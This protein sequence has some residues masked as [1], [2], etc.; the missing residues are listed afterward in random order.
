MALRAHVAPSRAH[1]RR[2]FVTGE[3]V[4]A[5]FDAA[6]EL[7]ASARASFL[8][9]ECGEDS[10]LLDEVLSLLGEEPAARGFLDVDAAVAGPTD[11]ELS[12]GTRFGDWIVLEPIGRGGFGHVLRA[13]HAITSEIAAI[14]TIRAERPEHRSAIRREVAALARVRHPG[15]VRV[16]DHGADVELPWYAME[17]VEGET[18]GARTR[19]G[20]LDLC[21]KLEIVRAVCD[22][23]AFLHGEGVVHGDLKPDN[24][25]LR[26]DG[27]PVLV[28]FGLVE[29][30]SA[31]GR[32]TL[33]HRVA[34]A[35]TLEYMAP[36]V[37]CGKPI[38]ARAD[39]YA[40]GCILHELLA[41][42]PPHLVR[43]LSEI[44]ALHDQGVAPALPAGLAPPAVAEICRSLLEP[45][46]RDRAGYAI[47]VVRA[48]RRAGS[49][50]RVFP[51]RA[52]ARPYLYGAELAGRT[53]VMGEMR[54]ALRDAG[55]GQSGGILIEGPMGSGKTRLATEIA[56][57]A[58]AR[59][60]LVL[61]GAAEPGGAPLAPLR[62]PLRAI[63]DRCRARAPLREIVARLAGPLRPY[64][65]GLEAFTPPAPPL[66]PRDARDRVERALCDTIVAASADVPILLAL[67]DLHCAD[68]ITAGFVRRI[69]PAKPREAARLLVVGTSRVDGGPDAFAQRALPGARRLALCPLDAEAVAQMVSDMLAIEAPP[70]RI[71]VELR[72][73]AEGN[74]FFVAQYL[75]LAMDAGLLRRDARGKWRVS[76]TGDIGAL[77]LPRSIRAWAER[78]LSELPDAA[79][80][81]V[82]VASVSGRDV[83]AAVVGSTCGLASDVSDDVLALLCRRGIV[84]KVPGGQRIACE[85]VRDVAY[86]ALPPSERGRL[87][88]MAAERLEETPGA[89]ARDL[90]IHWER[91]GDLARAAAWHLEA[92]RCAVSAHALEDAARHYRAHL[93]NAPAGKEAIDARIELARDV[94]VY[95]GSLDAAI[96]MARRAVEDA[97]DAP[98]RL[99]DALSALALSLAFAGRS[100]E[101]LAAYDDALAASA[102]SADRRA[103]A[104]LLRRKASILSECARYDEATRLITSALGMLRELGDAAGAA[105]C[106]HNLGGLHTFGARWDEARLSYESALDLI[107]GG[108]D[109]RLEAQTLAAFATL[110]ERTGDPEACRRLLERSLAISREIGDARSEGVALANLAEVSA[111]KIDL[112]EE[113]IQ[114]FREVGDLY[115]LALVVTNLAIE[116]LERRDESRGHAAATEALALARRLPSPVI[117]G[118]ALRL[119]AQV[120]IDG[121]RHAE[122]RGRIEAA[123]ELHRKTSPRELGKDLTVLSRLERIEGQL[124]AA[125]GA[126]TEAE[127]LLRDCDDRV[128]LGLCLVERGHL[129]AALGRDV[130]PLLA[131]LDLLLSRP[132]P[133]SSLPQAVRDLRAAAP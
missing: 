78:R 67:D 75:R 86:D 70:S 54:E 110:C 22:V 49:R 132:M 56:R 116:L 89:P 7:D 48:L 58:R 55:L 26:S 71:L 40:V 4:R 42:A 96:E 126:A 9:R 109:P 44:R 101:G 108:L 19:H 114:I 13:R 107:R 119:L 124:D 74:P 97:R 83:D 81:F 76:R 34:P 130:A 33:D 93:A 60:F 43:S 85:A 103:T 52:A 3:R 64:E 12:P 28:D 111:R 123:C 120:D 133:S 113:A 38:D 24:V 128:A 127:S 68:E 129:D 98:A 72:R 15:V 5:L 47:D 39:L 79:R 45:R 29:R 57:D 100:A 10:E 16:R 65:P 11:T 17:L 35:G 106:L 69:L 1:P 51:S 95:Q 62:E 84:E 41:G 61:A 14:K 118:M 94:L 2:G 92:A 121:G 131:E 77:P 20:G 66:P 88:R 99:L 53:A 73:H 90:A 91:G 30:F 25:L 18:L 117:E 87:H 46:P 21:R 122:A 102:A 105:R 115:H 8:E 23:L 59:G 37:A 6:L 50:R 125:F 112:Y 32:E 82:S 31:D 63:A 36:E 104:N 80:R 27:T